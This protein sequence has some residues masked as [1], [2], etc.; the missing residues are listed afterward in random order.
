MSRSLAKKLAAVKP[1]T[2]YA[3]VDLG[4]ERNYA[5]L[6]TDRAQILTQFAFPNDREGYNYF[7]R[8]LASWQSQQQAP[9]VLVGMEPT[10]YIWKLL[11][12]DLEQQAY[13]YRLVNPYT[14]KKR[15]E[16]D[17]LDHSR[18]DPRD[19][20]II[21]D[22]LRTA[23]YTETQ[24]L[25][26]LYAELRQTVVLHDRLQGELRRCKTLIRNSVGQL[27]P[28]INREFKRCAG[29]TAQALFHSGV[30]AHKI[31]S[32]SEEQ[33]IQRVRAHF[34]GKRLYVSKLRRVH[35]RARTSIGL[36]PGCQALQLGLQFQVEQLQALQI[37]IE[38]V[39]R[40]LGDTFLALPE[41]PAILSM[42]NL[43]LV[44]AATILGEIGDPRL[45]TA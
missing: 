12:A 13:R 16:G 41:A 22:L 39:A 44:T 37:Q 3:D 8:R 25:H 36:Q 27:F 19:A 6:I 21:A 34:L 24:L 43:G 10:N 45:T 38:Q 29:L 23:K 42:P 11:A 26:D 15:R 30:I 18:D 32:L 7:Y 5:M 35:Q 40:Q 33:F 20:F 1:G 14:V 4:L 31:P 9:E 28:E 2:L 17:Q